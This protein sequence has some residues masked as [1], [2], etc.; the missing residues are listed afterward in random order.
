[1]DERRVQEAKA[2]ART[3]WGMHDKGGATC[4]RGRETERTAAAK[5]KASASSH[6]TED[7]DDRRKQRT[8]DDKASSP[9]T[10]RSTQDD[11]RQQQKEWKDR[12]TRTSREDDKVSRRDRR[13]ADEDKQSKRHE[14]TR[15]SKS[16][17]ER[18]HRTPNQVQ[19]KMP[20]PARKATFDKRHG[21]ERPTADTA[22][23]KTQQ[24]AEQHAARKES[25]KGQP[26]KDSDVVDVR[27]RT[28]EITA[29]ATAVQQMARTGEHNDQKKTKKKTMK[30]QLLPSAIKFRRP[31]K[32]SESSDDN[33]GIEHLSR[34][35]AILAQPVQPQR[36]PDE[37]EAN[38]ILVVEGPLALGSPPLPT[39]WVDPT[40]GQWSEAP[41]ATKVQKLADE[42]D[43]S[44][45]S[46]Q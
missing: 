30:A 12:R 22:K 32:D 6:S 44:D 17:E 33:A 11:K 46:V 15:K 36:D 9:R 23:H 40:E 28:D 8:A 7:E 5:R 19:D 20:P 31:Q 13:A 29:D 10:R 18:K 24:S 1:M 42:S 37:F 39:P 16:R 21:E 26:R 41:K 34:T 3:A 35:E 43:E 14:D 38:N 2:K 45:K 25:E 4:S 27:S